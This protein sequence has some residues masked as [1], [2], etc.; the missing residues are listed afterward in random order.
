V[1]AGSVGIAAKQTAVYPFA[2]PGGWRL[3]GRAPLRM[4]QSG[5]DPMSLISIGDEVRFRSISPNEYA[6]LES[7]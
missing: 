7:S 1:P 6:A 5:R 4:F 3:I 2:T